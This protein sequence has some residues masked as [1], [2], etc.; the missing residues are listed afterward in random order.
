MQTFSRISQGCIVTADR[1]ERRRKEMFTEIRTPRHAA[2]VVS[3]LG[4]RDPRN[5]SSWERKETETETVPVRGGGGGRQS[6]ECF[7]LKTDEKYQRAAERES[8]RS[9]VG[10]RRLGRTVAGVKKKCKL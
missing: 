2:P 6:H 4:E 3:D 8:R 7:T 9:G 10:W 5:K 1:G